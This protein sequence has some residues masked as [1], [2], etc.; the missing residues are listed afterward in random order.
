MKILIIEKNYRLEKCMNPSRLAIKIVAYLIIIGLLIS[1]A[2]ILS[3]INVNAQTSALTFTPVADAYVIQSSPT[4]NAGTATNLRVDSSPITRSY[5]R[6]TVSG[7]NGGTVQS[8]KIRLFANSSNTTGYSVKSLSDNTWT[9][10]AISYSN[11]PSPGSLLGTSPAIVSGHW[12]EVDISSYITGEGTYNLVLDTTNTT[13]TSFGSRESGANA[14]QLVI[15]YGTSGP[16]A[17]I[18]PATATLSAASPTPT[19]ISPTSTSAASGV[20]NFTSSA[21]AY[22][23]QSSPTTNAGTATNLRIDSSPITRSYVRFVVSGLNSSP[24]QSAKIRLYANSSNTTGYSVKS[25]SDNSWTETGITYSNAPASGSLLGTSPTIVA[26]K[27][28]EVDIS[29]YIKAD[30]T[31]NLVLDTTNTTNTSF[32]SRE[33][34][35]NAPQLVITYGSSGPT[36]TNSPATPTLT[37]PAVSPT[38]T[39]TLSPA[40]P[41]LTM[42]PATPTLTKPAASPTPTQTPSAPTPT[43]SGSSTPVNLT[44]GPDLIYLGSNTSM[45]IFWQWTAAT[46]FSVNWGT[47][48]SYSLGSAPVSAYDTTNHLYKFTITGLSATTK[49]YYRVVVGSQYSAGTFYTS[50]SASATSLK[51]VSYGDTRSNPTQHDSVAAQ[52]ISL[53]QSDPGYQTILPLT[54]DLVSSGDTDSLWNSEF[55]SPSF[56]HIRTEAANVAIAPIMGNHE[57]SGGLFVRYWPEPFVAG[58]YYSFDYG[59]AHFTLIDQYTSYTVGSAQYN[60]IKSDLAASTKTWKIVVFHEP[61]WSAN[62]GHPDNT[63]V[64]TVLE[65]LFEQ[66]K[67]ALAL[68]GHNHYYARA[69]VNGIPE[70]TI[71]TGG[72][73]AYTPLSGQTDV[74]YTYKGLGY[75]KFSI[76]GSTLT[77]WFIDSSNTVRDTFTVTR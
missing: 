15:T 74:V 34:S 62:G 75:S 20:L 4:I 22:V 45:E 56:T 39:N 36:A 76:S 32:G 27:W 71:G 68:T 65:P 44:K 38:S 17:T 13:N 63:T 53:Y 37:Q 58:R 12:V 30:G 52:I 19:S 50:P 2:S 42:V 69:M 70:L 6:F 29:S 35:A 18:S 3:V 28:V 26:G 60:W 7:L 73:P 48:T 8:A 33:S 16:T 24:V 61:G 59:P 41:T 10:T 49:Y 47:D 51:F 77:G 31:Y 67:V 55:F 23:I 72:A 54:G 40:T 21:D 25:L 43:L 57:G 5:L 11:A 66:Y 14:P 46:N 64:Q 1:S 9:E